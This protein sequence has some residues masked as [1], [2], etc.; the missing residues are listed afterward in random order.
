MRQVWRGQGW[1]EGVWGQGVLP[2]RRSVLC[3]PIAGLEAHVV[4]YQLLP[5]PVAG[6]VEVVQVH[7]SRLCAEGP[8][9][10][11]KGFRKEVGQSSPSVWHKILPRGRSQ[12]VKLFLGSL[13]S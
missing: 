9:G 6:V 5:G 8:E 13:V 10:P 2:L 11:G 3:S 1:G 4:C 12:G 7:S